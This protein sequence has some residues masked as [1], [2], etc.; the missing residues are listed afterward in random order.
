MALRG[1]VEGCQHIGGFDRREGD[2]GQAEAGMVIEQVQ[3]LDVTAV[4]Q[5]PVGGVGL[6]ELVGQLGLKAYP[7]WLGALV[8][9][10]L[11]QALGLEDAP[12]GRPGGRPSQAEAEVVGDGLGT[13]VKAGLA[14][15]SPQLDDGLLNLWRGSAGA[16]DGPA[17]SGF[18]R[19]VAARSIA[20]EETE[21]PAAGDGVGSC[22]R[23][24]A[25]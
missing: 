25:W 20:G 16:R 10:R 8:W 5:Q 24:W 21:K 1:R 22:Q 3:D 17:G 13:G 18:Q 19:R 7:R 12:D 14:E 6:P 23:G 11:D 4:G 15:L 9:L 2:R